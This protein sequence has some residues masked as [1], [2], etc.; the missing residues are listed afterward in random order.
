LPPAGDCRL[1]FRTPNARPALAGALLAAALL[2]GGCRRPPLILAYDLAA[3]AAVAEREGPWQTILFGTPESARYVSGGLLQPTVRPS[4]DPFAWAQRSVE[5][6]LRWPDAAPRQAVLDVEPYPGLTRQAA[7][8]VLNDKRLGRFSLRPGRRRYRI[9]LP[10]EAQWSAGGE[11]RLRL[12]FEAASEELEA[13]GRPVAAAL[14]ALAVGPASSGVAG[15][16]ADGAPAPLSM[17]S[18]KGAPELVQAGPGALR[19]ALRLSRRAE[20]RF[21][22]AA[23]PPGASAASVLRVTL[24]DGKNERE[25]WKGRGG[26]TR[27][28]IVPLEGPEGGLAR[29][30]LHVDSASGG[31]V[32]ACWRTPRVFAEKP[33]T[34]VRA[35]P[36]AADDERVA[37]LRG[38]LASANVMLVVL[39]AASAKH[40]GCYG[41][42]RRTTPEL[43]RI[44]SE[45]VVFEEAFT[46]AA[47]TLAAMASVWTS[48]YADQHQTLDPRRPT[49]GR[50]RLVLPELLL[51]NGV[52]TAGFVANSMA[53][54]AFGF[55]RGFA[56]FRE[57]YADL[58]RRAAAFRQ[59]LPDWLAANTQRRFFAYVHYRE[60]HFP[61]DPEPPF[62][63]L[64]GPDG[65]I[66]PELRGDR[67]W[68]GAV[69]NRRLRISQEEVA[70]AERLYD[71]NLAYVDA[72]LG[73]LRRTLEQQGLWDRT[74]LIVTADHGEA[75]WEHEHIGH[76]VQLYEP[77]LRIPLI[78]RLPSGSGPAGVRRR[79]LADLVDLAPTIA[80][81]FGLLGKAGARE[82]F[83]GRSLL[84]MMLGGPGK[85][86]VLSRTVAHA[87]SHALRDRT[88][89]LIDAAGKRPDELYDLASD[90]GERHN[91]AGSDP[92]RA[93]LYRQALHRWL[94]DLTRETAASAD[95]ATLT[96]KQLEN[97]RALGYVQ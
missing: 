37:E 7:G 75:F 38:A 84:A 1:T 51:A 76:S 22:P 93:A 67:Q 86:A 81:V 23:P 70:H 39:D 89:K 32:W 62:D 65:P 27:E 14:Y 34:V 87:P 2:P 74:V 50:A 64:F 21:T 54:P 24:D 47:Y 33:A 82:A 25:V 91:L 9:G 43:D 88:H 61:Y 94:L 17:P 63:T 11:N 26:E 68:F 59:V 4:A 72:E 46:P 77:I 8:V 97:L 73:F 13:Y 20:L 15:L 60:P 18:V 36:P 31:A 48:Q 80:D 49:Y 96:R 85:P 53:G 58:G 56:E 16:A 92:L 79:G 10:A 55:D 83:Q 41:Y 30:G 71:G 66:P 28:V 69:D 3:M 78:V 90:P 5:L 35:V 44:A 52:H 42:P 57:V 12:E 6:V 29:L 95:G 40:F 45:G 19:F